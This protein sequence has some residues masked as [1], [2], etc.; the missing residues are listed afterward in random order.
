MKHTLGILG[1]VGR[2]C[3]AGLLGKLVVLRIASVYK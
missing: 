2:A 3:T 1:G